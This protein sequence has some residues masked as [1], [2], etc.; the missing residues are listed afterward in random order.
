MGLAK[1]RN[2]Q[3]FRKN[4]YLPE[5]APQKSENIREGKNCQSIL[6]GKLVP[7]RKKLGGD[8]RLLSWALGKDGSTD[9]WKMQRG[10]IRA[11]VPPPILLVLLNL[12]PQQRDARVCRASL[13]FLGLN[14]EERIHSYQKEKWAGSSTRASWDLA[15][16]RIRFVVLEIRVCLF[17]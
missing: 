14:V 11:S 1:K 9:A 10:G 7:E 15:Q 17:W 13:E 4:F 2:S 6:S 16:L 3:C 8:W 5:E 12:Y